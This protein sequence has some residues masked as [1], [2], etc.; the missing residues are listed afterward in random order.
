MRIITTREDSF[1]AVPL[2][3]YPR[4]GERSFGIRHDQSLVDRRELDSPW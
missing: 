1:G 2:E 4:F 3:R